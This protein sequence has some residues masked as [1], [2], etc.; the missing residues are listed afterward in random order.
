MIEQVLFYSSMTLF[1]IAGLGTL[2]GIA[3]SGDNSQ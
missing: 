3:S 1:G 2:Y